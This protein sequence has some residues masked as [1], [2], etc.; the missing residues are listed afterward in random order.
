[1]KVLF[2]CLGNICRSPLAEGIMKKLFMEHGIEG[3]IESAGTADWNVGSRADSRAIKVALENGIDIKNHRARQLQKAD[4][5]KFDLIIVMDRAN[6]NAV[7]KVAP[8]AVHHKIRRAL[9]DDLDVID[10]YHHDEEAFRNVF[11]TLW[12]SCDLLAKSVRTD[13][14]QLTNT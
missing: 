10:P 9:L 4:F 12:Q 1:V 11:K 8:Q 5:D 2:V 14:D 3:L 7:K 13:K 6:E